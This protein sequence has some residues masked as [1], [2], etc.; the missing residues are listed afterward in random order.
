MAAV[1]AKVGTSDQGVAIT[2]ERNNEG[3]FYV[4]W[5]ATAQGV[6]RHRL[7]AGTTDARRLEAHARGFIEQMNQ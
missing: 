4:I 6:K 5:K 3:T 2:I 1:A 7:H